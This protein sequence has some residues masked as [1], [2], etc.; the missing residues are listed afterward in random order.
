MTNPSDPLCNFDEQSISQNLEI[1]GFSDGSVDLDV[2]PSRY[3]V[4]ADM[5]DK[6]FSAPPAPDQLTMKER[7]LKYF[8][9]AV[10]DKYISDVKADLSGKTIT[11]TTK[12][13]YINVIK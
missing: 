2:I 5:V 1:A 8:D 11:V 7:F 3:I 9:E 4:N 10:V 6:W 13:L 12:S